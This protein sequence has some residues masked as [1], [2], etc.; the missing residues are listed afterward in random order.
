VVFRLIVRIKQNKGEK[1]FAHG[2]WPSI[3]QIPAYFSSHFPF[4]SL[5]V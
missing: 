4:G 2:K 5:S 3:A 1:S